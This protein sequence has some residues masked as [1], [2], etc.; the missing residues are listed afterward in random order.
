MAKP[1]NPFNQLANSVAM[2]EGALREQ[3]PN[4]LNMS[5][6]L[7]DIGAQTGAPGNIQAGEIPSVMG[8]ASQQAYVNTASQARETAA[9]RQAKQLP[10]YVSSYRNYL[11]WR[12]PSRYGGK[13]TGNYT[14]D[15]TQSGAD[16]ADIADPF[17][18]PGFNQ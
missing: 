3:T 16:I 10:A 12:Y 8:L 7:Q 9:K 14:T 5:G 2:R 4:I 13:K 15:Y 18:P 1:V 6:T 17:A 11:K